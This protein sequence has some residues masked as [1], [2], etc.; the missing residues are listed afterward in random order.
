MK[1]FTFVVLSALLL[2][3]LGCRTENLTDNETPVSRSSSDFQKTVKLKDAFPFKE[4]IE[5]N[6][7]NSGSV[8]SKGKE[9]FYSSLSDETEVLIIAKD[10]VVSYS[11]V[12]SYPDHSSDV[13]VYTE[14]NEN[15][16]F[17]FIAKHIPADPNKNYLIED[18]TGTVEYRTMDGVLMGTKELL[19]GTPLPSKPKTNN[20]AKAS[21]SYSL[22]LVEV[23]CHAGNHTPDQYSQCPLAADEKPYYILEIIETCPKSDPAPLSLPDMGLYGG[24]GGSNGG[25]NSGGVPVDT[26]PQD[27]FNLFLSKAGYP[28]LTPEQY[29]YVQNHQYAGSFLLGY[30]GVIFSDNNRQLILW[31]ID[32]LRMNNTFNTTDYQATK[33]IEPF[34]NFAQQFFTDNPN[35]AWNE[36]QSLFI[37]DDGSL[38]IKFNT[39]VSNNSMVFNNMTDFKNYIT[40]F[41]NSFIFESA[42]LESVNNTTVTKFKAKFDIVVPVY[43]NVHAKSILENPNTVTSE[44]DLLEVSSFKSGITT[45]LTWNQDSYGHTVNGHVVEIKLNGHFDIGVKIGE[46]DFTYADSYI[47]KAKYNNITGNAM[48]ISGTSD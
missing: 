34:I 43:L 10:P 44:F 19:K 37:N 45:F 5:K 15:R 4:F 25:G 8:Y 32:Y 16:S 7:I 9:Q 40:N 28:D 6:K 26:L 27:A 20:T 30:L 33:K 12:V 11:T 1:K 17:G 3:L 29:A 38:K 48:S 46:L 24:G 35:V 18:F 47:I 23:N 36:F 14:D 13:L 39:N 41:K 31:A 21:C 2:L 42:E 22:N